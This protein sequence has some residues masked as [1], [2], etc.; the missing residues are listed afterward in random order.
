MDSQN[1]MM[2]LKRNRTW[3]AG[4][5]AR[6]MTG[7]GSATTAGTPTGPIV[8]DEGRGGTVSDLRT[9]HPECRRMWQ[10]VQ[11]DALPASGTRYAAHR[12]A[13]PQHASL[14]HAATQHASTQHASTQHAAPRQH[15]APNPERLPNGGTFRPGAR[16]NRLPEPSLAFIRRAIGPGSVEVPATPQPLQ[17]TDTSPLRHWPERE[18]PRERLLRHGAAA[19]SDAELLA[20]LLRTG[21]RGQSAVA[22]AKQ[23]LADSGTSLSRLLTTEPEQ[24]MRM[25]GLGPARATTL[26][27]VVELARRV[28]VE[29]MEDSILINS[30]EIVKEYLGITLRGLAREVFVVIFLN[31]QHRLI[32]ADQLFAGTLA[33][34]P[35]FPREVVKRALEL[36]AA[37]VILAHNH[38]SGLPTPSEADRI[39]T[40]TL[41]TALG[42]VD[43]AGTGSHH[44]GRGAAPFVLGSWGAVKPGP[45]ASMCH[46]IRSRCTGRG[47]PRAGAAPAAAVSRAGQD[48]RATCSMRHIWL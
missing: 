11:E 9:G 37:A 10:G 15:P 40:R 22:L 2:K 27:V 26:A 39:L 8:W 34:T 29:K 45:A 4:H 5:R 16:S 14:R 7:K 35:V 24:L 13:V 23:L 32:R 36:N 41:Q 48:R 25:D 28:L 19:L 1:Q 6:K 21:N 33:Q 44:R 46:A 12:H 17:L 20:I 42:H 18:R 30:P 38:P 31:A 43:G 3:I 47:E